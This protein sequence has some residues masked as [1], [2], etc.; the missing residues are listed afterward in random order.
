[1]RAQH[2][3]FTGQI[4]RGIAVWAG[5][6]QPTAMSA[7][8]TV[9]IHYEFLNAPRANVL[10]P[11]LHDRGD[12]QPIPHLHSGEA[13]CLYQPRYREWRP[14]LF[15][16]DTIVPWAALWLYYYE[17]WHITGEWLGGGEH[18]TP[19]PKPFRSS[20]QNEQPLSSRV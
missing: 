16:A 11:A 17:V 3:Q 4:H 15:I 5:E 12:G 6:I 9:R 13:L 2:P 10:T 14:T 8:Y 1:M 18:P 19:P 20:N 7:K